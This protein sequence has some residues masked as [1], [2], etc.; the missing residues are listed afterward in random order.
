MK[1]YSVPVNGIEYACVEAGEGPLLLLGH[2]TFGGKALMVPQVEVLSRS[3][4]CV[5]FDWPGHGRS[6]Y[7][8]GGWTADELGEDVV[9]L[10]GALGEERAMLACVSQGGAIAMRV[11]IAHPDRVIA[12]CNI[13]GGPGG[14][15]PPV[16]EKLYAFAAMIASEPD[17]TVRRGALAEFARA[18]LHSPGFDRREP[19]RFEAELDVMLSH[20]KE[21]VGLLF[22]VPKSYVDITADLGKISC[23][24]LIIWGENEGRPQMGAQLAVVI[25]DARLVMIENAGHHANVEAPKEIAAA[26]EAFFSAA[27]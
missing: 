2:G 6:G 8:P 22:C 5:A 1:E 27:I 11:A 7:R 4:R 26:M 13:C 21:S 19:E 15:S 16:I 24:T 9:A 14:P 10:I 20:P 17:E 3:F 25:P 23:P 18:H 12:L